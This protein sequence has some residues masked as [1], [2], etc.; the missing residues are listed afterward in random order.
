MRVG[1][2]SD[3]DTEM[4]ARLLRRILVLEPEKRPSAAE[5]VGDEWFREMA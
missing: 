2:A 3:D 5:I 1:C 4:L